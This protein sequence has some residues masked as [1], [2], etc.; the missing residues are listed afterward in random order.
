MH[1]F[2][3]KLIT[4]FIGSLVVFLLLSISTQSA[5][6]AFRNADF[7]EQETTIVRGC[8]HNDLSNLFFTKNSCNFDDKIDENSEGEILGI[9][10]G[11]TEKVDGTARGKANA[12]KSPGF[13]ESAEDKAGS[14]FS[15]ILLLL[16][17]VGSFIIYFVIKKRK[18]LTGKH[19]LE[20]AE[21]IQ[22]QSNLS[23]K[24]KTFSTITQSVPTPPIES[25]R[26]MLFD[27]NQRLPRALK[28]RSH[29]SLTD[30]TERIH[31]VTP[32]SPYFV[33]RYAAQAE[34]EALDAQAI[35]HFEQDLARYL[36][37]QLSQ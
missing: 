32:L 36:K 10:T 14:S 34:V 22:D 29:E 28:R 26:L 7:S 15:I 35:H 2:R 20:S 33:T 25:L 5:Y 12:T 13:L 37:T 8:N 16:L 17:L 18:R 27:F 9:S 31:L 24:N 11:K 23:F 21:A 30:W 19:T 3:A 1:T 4:S 6:E